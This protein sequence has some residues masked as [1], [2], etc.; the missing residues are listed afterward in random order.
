MKVALTL[1]I[2]ILAPLS[3][4]GVSRPGQIP[5][6]K[7]PI[8]YVQTDWVFC[9]FRALLKKKRPLQSSEEMV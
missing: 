3:V 1:N 5:K 4:T 2:I 7:Y 8:R 9:M 6:K